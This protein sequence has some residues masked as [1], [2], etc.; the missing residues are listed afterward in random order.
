MN[1]NILDMIQNKFYIAQNC[2]VRRMDK[3]ARREP[4]MQVQFSKLLI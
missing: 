1:S 3:L 2:I 4:A